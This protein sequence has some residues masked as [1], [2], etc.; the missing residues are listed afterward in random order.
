MQPTPALTLDGIV[1]IAAQRI[2]HGETTI[3]A[4]AL[5]FVLAHPATPPATY[6]R[7]EDLFLDLEAT[8]CP[9]V[10]L[11]AQELART[12]TLPQLLSALAA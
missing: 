10:I 2:G 7:A 1:T 5:A 12:L 3:A 4:N 6:D 9:R 8:I 11:D